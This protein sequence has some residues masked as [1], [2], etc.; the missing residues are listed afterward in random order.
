MATQL[1]LNI[2]FILD[3]N[4]IYILDGY[5]FDFRCVHVIVSFFD[6]GVLQNKDTWDSSFFF[7]LVVSVCCAQANT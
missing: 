7:F 2:G 3:D 4:E 5:S 1:G 6:S